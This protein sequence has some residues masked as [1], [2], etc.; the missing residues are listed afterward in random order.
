MV[1]GGGTYSPVIKAWNFSSVPVE[2]DD[3]CLQDR[4][5]DFFSHLHLLLP[6]LFFVSP[7]VFDSV[8]L[9]PTLDGDRSDSS[10]MEVE[11]MSWGI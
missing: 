9:L 6:D 2:P 7:P 5:Q 10:V 1:L 4:K 8:S 11:M 3:L